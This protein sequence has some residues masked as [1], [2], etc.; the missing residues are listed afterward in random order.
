MHVRVFVTLLLVLLFSSTSATASDRSFVY[1]SETKAL[2][3]TVVC[4]APDSPDMDNAD[5][6]SENV[7]SIA[8]GFG[9]SMGSCFYP[10]Q[11]YTELAVGF[12]TLGGGALYLTQDELD[13]VIAAAEQY[14]NKKPFKTSEVWPPNE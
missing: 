7:M 4:P 1:R 8:R 9:F 3:L 5:I 11:G 12:F 10:V 6:T 2:S 14:G 13:N